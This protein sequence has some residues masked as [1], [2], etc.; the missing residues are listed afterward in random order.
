M[1]GGVN[2]LKATVDRYAS[3]VG[4]GLRELSEG[5]RHIEWPA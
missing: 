1:T 4:E 2:G 3:K 5:R